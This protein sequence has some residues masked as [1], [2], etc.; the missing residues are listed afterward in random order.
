MRQNRLREE[1]DGKTGAEAGV[2]QPHAKEGLEP[3]TL[4]ETGGVRLRA[5]EGEQRP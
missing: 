2:T 4:Q 3:Q 1:G 5:F